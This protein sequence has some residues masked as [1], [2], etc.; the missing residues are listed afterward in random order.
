MFLRITSLTPVHIMLSFFTL[1]FC[2][3]TTYIASP[4]KSYTLHVMDS[5]SIVNVRWRLMLDDTGA[6]QDE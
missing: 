4:V 2:I 3:I 5:F 1:S 6:S